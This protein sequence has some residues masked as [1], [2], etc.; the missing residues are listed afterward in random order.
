MVVAVVLVY[1]GLYVVLVAVVLR[2]VSRGNY[3]ANGQLLAEGAEAI[4]FLQ[5]I[6]LFFDLFLH[7][8]LL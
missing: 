7:V 3:H 1:D 5:S 8:A 4:F 6:H 2:I